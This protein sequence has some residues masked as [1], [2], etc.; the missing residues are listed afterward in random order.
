[1]SARFCDCGNHMDRD[2]NAA[3]NLEKYGAETFKPTEKR[4]QEKHKTPT[5]AA[6]S[7]VDGVNMAEKTA[8]NADCARHL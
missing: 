4:A 8:E 7:F 5:L 1:M 3:I 2:L 6:S